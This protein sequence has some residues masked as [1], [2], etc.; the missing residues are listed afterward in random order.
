[1]FETWSLNCKDRLLIAAAIPET[2]VAAAELLAT[3]TA[4]ESSGLDSD[5]TDKCILAFRQY[6]SKF[7]HVTLVA[8]GLLQNTNTFRRSSCDTPFK[9]FLFVA[10][11]LI[12]AL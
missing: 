2:S 8:K 10:A 1:M 4:S 3:I 7:S 5:F 9:N 11:N 6:L 12:A